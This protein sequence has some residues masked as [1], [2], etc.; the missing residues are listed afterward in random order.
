MGRVESS[1]LEATYGR[2]LHFHLLYPRR[3]EV[4]LI[5]VLRDS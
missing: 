2:S 5:G 3:P 1:T 4:L